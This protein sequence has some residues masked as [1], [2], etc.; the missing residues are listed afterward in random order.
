[1]PNS[2]FVVNVKD[3]GAA[4]NGNADDTAAIQ[5]AVDFCFIGNEVQAEGAVTPGTVY[6]PP[7]DYRV[8][9]PIVMA[10]SSIPFHCIFTKLSTIVKAGGAGGIDFKAAL[11]SD[12]RKLAKGQLIRATQDPESAWTVIDSISETEIIL[13]EP[14]KGNPHGDAQG[15]S[16]KIQDLSLHINSQGSSVYVADQLKGTVTFTAGSKVV[17]GIDTNF[18]ADISSLDLGVYIKILNDPDSLHF[19]YIK[20]IDSEKQELTLDLPYPISISG[21]AIVVT[22]PKYNKYFAPTLKGEGSK[23]KIFNY[24][25]PGNPTLLITQVQKFRIE[26]LFVYGVPNYPNT[27]IQIGDFVIGGTGDCVINNVDFSANGV[28]LRLVNTYTN[29]IRDCKYWSSGGHHGSGTDIAKNTN[30]ILAEGTSV[31]ETHIYNLYV[32]A[33]D[34][35]GAGI[36]W[37]TSGLSYNVH[38]QGGSN[39]YPA[40]YIDLRNVT[41]GNLFAVSGEGGWIKITASDTVLINSAGLNITIGDETLDGRCQNVMSMNSHSNFFYADSYNLGCGAINSIFYKKYS[42][43]SQRPVDINVQGNS[44]WADPSS[45]YNP[46]RLSGAGLK[47]AASITEHN[48]STPI[49]EWVSPTY[50]TSKFRGSGSLVWDVKSEDVQIQKYTLI[51]YT[52]VLNWKIKNSSIS[53]IGN[54]LFLQIP[55]GWKAAQTPAVSF[56]YRQN[57]GHYTVG[58]ANISQ[59]MLY[60]VMQKLDKSNWLSPDDRLTVAGSMTFPVVSYIPITPPSVTLPISGAMPT[61][62]PAGPG[63]ILGGVGADAGGIIILPSGQLIPYPPRSPFTE[64]INKLL[65][66]KEQS[67]LVNND[68]SKTGLAET[69]SETRAFDQLQNKL[70]QEHLALKLAREQGINRRS[71]VLH[72]FDKEK[73]KL[74]VKEKRAFHQLQ[75]NTNEEKDEQVAKARL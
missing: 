19:A 59:D 31:N 41:F 13:T 66:T 58:K 20:S 42:N 32:T 7:G 63:T 1:M 47:T 55:Y 50:Y 24:A 51:G 5:A 34:K 10:G 68:S 74:S 67:A 27:G 16:I 43:N 60:V 73:P 44:K 48:R 56:F 36:R 52:M 64:A 49:G 35:D 72:L 4:G 11:I 71:M 14:Y 30:A 8:T 33:V 45:L 61:P 75:Q 23:S 57:G 65:T 37:D 54:Q 62:S 18:L 3:F 22:T 53:G 6:F 69:E 26:D 2:I 28:G 38:I 40:T 12:T 29:Q 15:L 9:Q 25:S 46:D 21:T 17:S 39:E 70:L